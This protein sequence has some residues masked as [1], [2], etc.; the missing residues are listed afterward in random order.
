MKFTAKVVVVAAGTLNSSPLLLRSELPGLSPAGIPVPGQQR[1]EFLW[2][3]QFQGKLVEL[4]SLAKADCAASA[5]LRFLRVPVW[6]QDEDGE[7]ALSDFRFGRFLKASAL[8]MDLRVSAGPSACPARVPN[9]DR[10]R[11]DIL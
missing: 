11:A 7:L 10:P 4:Q 6:R 3:V 8:R 5:L 1:P 9:W 2:D